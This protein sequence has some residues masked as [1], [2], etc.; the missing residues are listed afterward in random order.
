MGKRYAKLEARYWSLD[1]IVEKQRLALIEARD[2][3]NA[4]TESIRLLTLDY[5]QLNRIRLLA[6]ETPAP[7]LGELCIFCRHNPVGGLHA[8]G[9]PWNELLKAI[10]VSNEVKW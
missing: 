6:K 8:P 9:C 3:L 7:T 2:Q 10:G 5:E 1:E 4:S